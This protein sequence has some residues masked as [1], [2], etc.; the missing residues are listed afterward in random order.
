[1]VKVKKQIRNIAAVGV[2][3]YR[4]I[5]PHS[6]GNPSSTAQNEADY[7]SRKDLTSGYFT[8]V[9]GN[10]Q[11]IQT[12]N[13]NRGAWDV[14]G[15]W[16]YETYA[17]VELIE[18]HKTQAEFDRDYKLYVELIRELADEGNITK[19]LD[20]SALEGI[21]THEY[22]TKNQP[23]NGSDHVDPYPYLAKW[24]ISRSQFKKDVEKGFGSVNQYWKEAG[25]YEMLVDDTFY[26]DSAFKKKSGWKVKKGSRI[27][28][29][30]IVMYGN[31]PRGEVQLG[32]A[33]R[34]ITMNKKRIKKV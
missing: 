32:N 17:A 15:G 3:P 34:L 24:G 9:V 23:N 30:K 10:G 7:M 29:D 22:C 8:H 21:K 2:K 18:S 31:I 13:V 16:N 11:V 28:I 25:W 12:A 20:E 14:G 27:A 6:T 1:M 26:I 19:K 4:Q 33:K 5:H